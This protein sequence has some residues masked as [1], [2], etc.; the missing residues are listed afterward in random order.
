MGED[1]DMKIKA[2]KKWLDE[3]GKETSDHP[4][5]VTINL[6]VG[7]KVIDTAELNEKN[8]WSCEFID[9][10]SEASLV[11]TTFKSSAS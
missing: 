6:K 11:R 2:E 3:E 10:P 5:S 4:A 9:L 1:A 8:G 7:D